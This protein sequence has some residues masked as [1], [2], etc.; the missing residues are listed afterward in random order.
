MSFDRLAPHYRW[1]EALLA[2]D[3][4]QRCR[5]TH[6]AGLPAVGEI[7]LLGEGH[8]RFLVP[9]RRRFPEARI[10]CVDSSAGMIA[11][12]RSAVRRAG[13]D[14]GGIRFLRA[15]VPAWNFAAESFDLVATHFFLDCFPPG[16]LERV[17][18]RTAELLRPDGHWLLA[19]FQPGG[20]GLARARNR[21]VLVAM[22]RFFRVATRLPARSLTRP[23]GWLRDVG[24]RLHRRQ[25][26]EWGLL[27][28]D[29]WC[30]APAPT[31]SRAGSSR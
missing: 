28:S 23:D 21:L 31:S 13:L 29:W 11:R 16:P 3:K 26:S 25:E 24:L 19:D 1:M 17:V 4:L 2:G 5:T 18:R 27:H 14:E 22:Y 7:L 9:C 6:L 15:E 20:T 30:K 8:G 10:T 12:A